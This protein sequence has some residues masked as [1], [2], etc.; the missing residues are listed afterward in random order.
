M[1]LIKE[2]KFGSYL[3]YTPRGE[4]DSAKRSKN[5]M[6]TLKNE[7]KI[8]EPPKLISEIIAEQIKKK[9]NTLPFKDFFGPEVLLVPVPKSSLRHEGTLWVPDR[10]VK[11]LEKQGLGKRYVCLKR[12]IAVN[13]SA[14]STNA[15]RPKAKQHYESIKCERILPQPT[16]IVLIDDIV[17]RGSTLLGCASK[18]KEIFPNVLIYAFAAIRTIS[19]ANDFE[20]IENPCIGKINL[21]SDGNT[22][23]DP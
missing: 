8:G 15:D 9:I 7:H 23:R 13:K 17:T 11:A 21:L 5:L 18:L 1:S 6:L 19:V 14:V 16:R 3:T 12:V 22:H 2:V 4:S 20:K 10:I